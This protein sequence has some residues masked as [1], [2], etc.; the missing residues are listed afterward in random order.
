MTSESDDDLPT[1]LDTL[2]QG[3]D[4]GDEDTTFPLDDRDLGPFRILRKL[5][6]GGM[7]QV[8]LAR[9]LRP[10]ERDVA[11]KLVL[12]KMLNPHALA[13]FEVE[14]Q[15]LAQMSHPAIAQVFDAG[16]TPSGYPYF[17]M[18]FVDGE[19]L[20]QFCRRHRL[21]LSERLRLMIRIC[22]GVQH[23]HQRGIIHR[24]LKPGNILVAKI[25]GVPRPKIIDF[26]IARATESE[27]EDAVA[28]DV[29]G[30]PQYM[31]P[32][33]F[34]L[35]EVVLDPRS[36]VYSLGVILHELLI[37]SPP[38]AGEQLSQVDS[39]TI[40]RIFSQH[41]PLKTPSTR[42]GQDAETD[43]KVAEQRQTSIRRLR[44]RLRNDLDAI[45][46]KAL[47]RSRDA[48]YG[49]PKDLADDIERA[50]GHFPVSAVPD[51]PA[52]RMRRFVQ[53]N[54]LAVGSASAIVLALV[55]GMTA[56]TLGMLEAQ[57]QFQLA[58][59]RQAELEQVTRFQQ[60]MLTGLDPQ[61][62]G[63]AL[64]GSLREQ[65]ADSLEIEG[66]ESAL[67]ALERILS[68]LN[69]TDIAR[70]V[71]DDQLLTQAREAIELQ[72]ADQPLVRADLLDSIASVYLAI[73]RNAPALDLSRQ[74]LELRRTNLSP[75]H[76]E[77]L[78]AWNVYGNAYYENG[79]LERAEEE[80]RALVDVIDTDRREEIPI[81]ITARQHLAVI[82]VDQGRI[83]AALEL[84]ENQPEVL[85]SAFADDP[86]LRIGFNFNAGYVLARAGRIEE[87]LIEFRSALDDS[88]ELHGPD[89]S[90]TLRAMTNVGAALGALGR[91]EEALEN[92]TGLL[93]R[94]SRTV[95]R[96]HISTL[97]VMSNKANNLRRLDRTQEAL[98][99]LREARE[100]GLDLLG[101]LHPVTMRVRLNLGSLL[102]HLGQSEKGLDILDQVVEDRTIV[103]GAD[104]P[105]TLTAMEVQ[106]SNLRDQKRYQQ[107]LARIEPVIAGRIAA[108][109]A[110][111]SSVEQARWL[112]A[113]LQRDSGELGEALP[114]IQTLAAR[115]FEESPRANQT[116]SRAVDLY[117]AL[118]LAG[119]E[120]AA[121]QWRAEALA[122]LEAR[123]PETL[124]SR[125]REIRSRLTEWSPAA[126]TRKSAE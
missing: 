82:L 53:R 74:V 25:D 10:V 6:E 126:A 116:L 101:P 111:H 86:S 39:E 110:D 51:T 87:A 79:Q 63:L 112:K 78:E 89:H 55:A 90:S 2:I 80:I 54:R 26:G 15:A 29:V 100:I 83:D 52:Y 5:G 48:R 28:R 76:I 7:G 19:P 70:R 32:E 85:A 117:K 94:I 36:D 65:Y 75:D 50:L 115:S 71:L 84:I 69:A 47:A 22:Q 93:D 31:S 81:L 119:D 109:G 1:R 23:A 40:D 104:H 9:Q 4:E 20:G 17:A 58:E 113:L 18:E 21:S 12:R 38:I 67:T 72:F 68:R 16:T 114:V 42:L 77:T 108:F 49:S 57:R 27:R 107:G 98:A 88:L 124:D 37:G 103:F 33:Q 120:Q 118:V 24:D 41:D 102:T 106:V 43:R 91:V 96:R 95:G 8:Y 35:D 73:G 46:L 59:Q 13:R 122:W 56:A 3:P 61:N 125:Q 30:T 44:Q 123:D 99:L 64:L 14:Q 45:T 60:E 11:L 34:S 97:R 121:E 92:D 66:R 105:A 62:I